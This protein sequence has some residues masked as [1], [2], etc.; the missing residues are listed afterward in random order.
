MTKNLEDLDKIFGD[1]KHGMESYFNIKENY[2]KYLKEKTEFSEEDWE[3]IEPLL[4]NRIRETNYSKLRFWK[5]FEGLPFTD[6]L[7]I[8]FPEY[9]YIKLGVLDKF[10][11]NKQ[12]LKL[13]NYPMLLLLII[14]NGLEHLSFETSVAVLGKQF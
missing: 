11:E 8:L 1:S 5:F 12:F 4:I 10:P 6:S 3:I 14:G 7:R 2:S 13:S 9:F